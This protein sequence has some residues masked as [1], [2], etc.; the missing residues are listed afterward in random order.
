MLSD[1]EYAALV[2]TIR[3]SHE[4]AKTHAASS[5]SE[6]EPDPPPEKE[7]YP[8]NIPQSDAPRQSVAAAKDKS[9]GVPTK[10]VPFSATHRKRSAISLNGQSPPHSE[11]AEKGVI[12]SMLRAPGKV[13]GLVDPQAF[14]IPALKILHDTICEWPEADKCVDFVWLVDQLI[15]CGQLDEV[16]GKECLSALFDFVQTPDN[17]PHYIRI[18]Q[19]KFALRQLI[20]LSKKTI[21]RCLD[22]EPDIV[23]ITKEAQVLTD[24]A[25]QGLNEAASKTYFEVLAPSQIRAYKP[26]PD[27]VL[28]GDNHFVRGNVTIIGGAPGVGKSRS[29]IAGAQSGATGKDWFGLPCHGN[30]RS[31]IIQ[32]EN[33]RLRLQRELADIDEPMLDEYVRISPPPQYGLCFWKRE[34]RDQ[35][36]RVY[37][38]FGPQLVGI[39]PWNAVARDE[40]AR[41][42]LETFEII[43]EVFLPGDDGPVLVII[44]HTRKPQAGERANGRALLNLIAG[45]YVLIS[46]PR[47]V[48]ILQHASDDVNEDKVVMTCC[49]NNDGDLGD[50]GAWIRKNGLFMP[51]AGFDWD[52]WDSGE[53]EGKKGRVFT[54]EKVAEILS[55][56]SKGLP[57]GKLV[58]E[59]KGLGASPATAYR[60]IDEAK[61]AGAIK[62]QKGSDSYV[63]VDA[64]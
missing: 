17:A 18:V 37:E 49:K 61:K 45:S 42:Y 5:G 47:T 20:A 48:F 14:F 57:K 64:I 41:E 27:L 56:F 58:K 32:S 59:L 2:Q 1:D 22:Y 23:N 9:T 28:I 50:R 63:S 30:F 35:C 4:A 7:S 55:D 8:P 51:V 34:F 43:R 24:E 38:T 31:L 39:D 54:P 36:R 44:A 19:E 40:R 10:V 26:P 12:C 15:N 25:L 52:D 62:F 3:E 29:L 16:G 21:H 60:A 13:V 53:N 6:Q 46:V 11:D 33:G